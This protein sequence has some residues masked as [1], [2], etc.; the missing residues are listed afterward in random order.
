LAARKSITVPKPS[1]STAKRFPSPLESRRRK[2]SR[3]ENRLRTSTDYLLAALFA[4]SS[5]NRQPADHRPEPNVIPLKFGWTFRSG[6]QA[7]LASSWTVEVSAKTGFG[8]DRLKA[9]LK[10]A[11]WAGLHKRPSPP[12]GKARLM[13]RDRLRKML[14]SD[15]KL[16][17]AKRKH[18]LIKRQAFDQ[19]CTKIGGIS[20]TEALLGFFHHSGV[21]FYRPGLFQNQIVLDQNWALDAIYALFDREPA[22]LVRHNHPQKGRNAVRAFFSPE[23][24]ATP[25]TRQWEFCSE[26]RLYPPVSMKH[27]ILCGT[28]YSSP[29]DGAGRF[30]ANRWPVILLS[31]RIATD[32]TVRPMKTEDRRTCP[33]CGNE[34][35]GA[36]EKS[37]PGNNQN[38]EQERI[39]EILDYWHKIEFFVPFDLEKMIDDSL[40]LPQRRR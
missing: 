26:S 27:A 31:A 20:D 21:L 12:I 22:A 29:G 40:C 1:F 14:A 7:G 17:S 30:H 13:V 18:R 28:D 16:S 35:S 34:F 11:A 32:G 3:Q 4:L 36:M 39:L 37:D 19:F 23:S 38:S 5:R 8:L 15:Q 10:D 9:T 25:K 33:S 6:F 24:A 2:D